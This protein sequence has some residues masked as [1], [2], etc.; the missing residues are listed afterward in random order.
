MNYFVVFILSCFVSHSDYT[1]TKFACAESNV[2]EHHP[3]CETVS[4][5]TLGLAYEKYDVLRSRLHETGSHACDIKFSHIKAILAPKIM[6]VRSI[7]QNWLTEKNLGSG[8]PVK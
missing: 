1:H 3:L 4:S 6:K 7:H 5:F 8:M 2:N